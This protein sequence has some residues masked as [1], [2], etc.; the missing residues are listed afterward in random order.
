M[1]RYFLKS[2][3]HNLTS[4]IFLMIVGCVSSFGQNS[5]SVQRNALKNSFKKEH[6]KLNE[7]WRFMKYQA[8]PDNLIYDIRPEIKEVNDSKVADSKPD[9]AVKVE[10]KEN[11]LKKWI[12][13]SANDFIKDIAKKH[14][15]PAGE[16]GADFPFVQNGFADENWEQVT[17]PHDWAIK[18]PFYEGDKPEVGGGMGRL[19]SQGV[20][21]YRKKL[22]ISNA[23]KGKIIYLD[24]DGAMSYAMV[25]LNG[26]LVGGWTYGYNSFRLDLTPYLN[27]GGVNQLAI[28]LD[29]PNHSAR[30]YPGGGLYRNVWLNK[31][32]PVH[33]AQWGTFI[34]TPNVSANEASIN[35]ALK[36]ENKAKTAQT[37]EAKTVLYTLDESGRVTGNVLGEFKTE[38]FTVNALQ[39]LSKESKLTLKNPKL[40]GIYPSQKPNMMNTILNLVFGTL[41]LIH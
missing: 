10:V 19:P 26:H 5:K 33:V 4:F 13:P 8:N 35:L 7:G 24:I 20:A 34:T 29:N 6:I 18:G 41:N 12:L 15:R 28:R 31:V 17:L 40:W 21:W 27:F 39:N 2:K 22:A 11:V 9:E 32:A 30:W 38:K 14:I 36:I 1:I 16:P 23:D 25:W 3:S 37:V